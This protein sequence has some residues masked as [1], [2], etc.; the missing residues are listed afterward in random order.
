MNVPIPYGLSI[1]D[2]ADQVVLALSENGPVP[3]LESQSDWREWAQRLLEL[4]P[5][6]QQACPAPGGF[7]DWQDWAAR[8][9]FA[10]N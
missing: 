10:V 6:V 4:N 7:D 5:A 2:W 9:A 1:Q 3:E 8:F